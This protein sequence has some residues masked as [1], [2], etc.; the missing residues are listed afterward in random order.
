[1]F[2][3][4]LNTLIVQHKLTVLIR[5]MPITWRYTRVHTYTQQPLK[6]SYVAIATCSVVGV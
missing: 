5:C 6:H 1:M 4:F 3:D 2:D